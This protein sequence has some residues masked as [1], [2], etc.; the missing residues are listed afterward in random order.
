M[1][2]LH[3]LEKTINWLEARKAQVE[4]ETPEIQPFKVARTAKVKLLEDLI[5]ELA[6]KTADIRCAHEAGGEM[7]HL[8]LEKKTKTRH[9]YRCP[10]CNAKRSLVR[11]YFSDTHVKM[12]K[13]IFK[14]CIQHRTHNIQTKK[15]TELDHVDYCNI[16]QLQRFGFLYYPEGRENKKR[17]GK[18]GV[19]VKRIYQFLQGD[20]KVA[21]YSQRD[22]VTKEQN[23]S[24][25][26]VDIHH[27][28]RRGLY[29]SDAGFLPYF[30]EYQQQQSEGLWQ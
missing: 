3:T 21:E 8:L 18:W 10:T 28:R 30:V 16:A 12:L 15:L 2:D 7:G 20:W 29:T 1:L 6:S 4:K 26:R 9:D 14:Y 27:I 25:E 13:K 11:S 22:T 19:A 24:E 5:H 17:D 23:V